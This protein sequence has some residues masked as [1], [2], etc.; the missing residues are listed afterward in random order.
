VIVTD[1]PWV[2]HFDIDVMY[3]VPQWGA[4]SMRAAKAEYETKYITYQHAWGEPESMFALIGSNATLRHAATLGMACRYQ[5][6]CNIPNDISTMKRL[7]E[8]LREGYVVHNEF[9]CNNGQCVCAS[10]DALHTY[11]MSAVKRFMVGNRAIHCPCASS[12]ITVLDIEKHVNNWVGPVFM[13][14]V[15]LYTIM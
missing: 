1:D 12:D 11:K 9:N 6:C 10:P 14:P 7:Y 5:Q 3:M 2:P 15:D 4:K 8:L 13:V